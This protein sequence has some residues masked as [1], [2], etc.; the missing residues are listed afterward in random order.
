M[1]IIIT[2]AKKMNSSVDYFEA[3]SIPIF[4]DKT[5][6]ILETIKKLSLNQ[7]KELLKCNDKIA[8]EMYQNYQLLNLEARGIPALFAYKGIEYDQLAPNIFTDLQYQYIKKNLRILSGFYGILRPFDSVFP[9]R[10]ELNDKLAIGENKNLYDF[11]NSLIYD[12]LID[13]DNCIL[14]LGGKQY[15]RIIKKYLTKDIHYVKC[16]FMDKRGFKYQEIGVYVKKARGEMVRYLVENEIDNIE[17][18][19]GFNRLGYRFSKELSN[20]NSYVFVR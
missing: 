9:Y 12:T 5:K 14:D 20:Q 15:T 17:A 2:P 4:I 16:F 13:G 7:L 8:L 11:W 6:S 19:K 1:R 18:V 10:L 3:E